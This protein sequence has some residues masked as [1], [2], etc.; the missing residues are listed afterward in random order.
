MQFNL[1]ETQRDIQ[2]AARE[3]AEKEFDPELALELDRERKFPKAIFE[4]A[5]RLGFIGIDYPEEYGGQSFGLFENVVA[6]IFPCFC[7]L[8]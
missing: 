3:F 2:K 4:K 5:C 1:T 8:N 6:I 7:T